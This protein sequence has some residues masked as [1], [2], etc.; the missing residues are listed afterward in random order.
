MNNEHHGRLPWSAPKE[1][2][3]AQN[4]SLYAQLRDAHRQNERLLKV[5][6]YLW[7]AIGNLEM[8]LLQGMTN[9]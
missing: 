4:E 8:A 6:R 5:N 2:V 7:W 9:E 1:M 3:E